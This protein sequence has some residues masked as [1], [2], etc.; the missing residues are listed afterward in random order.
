MKVKYTIFIA[1]LLFSFTACVNEGDNIQE[2]IVAL[3]E[4]IKTNPSQGDMAQLLG[5]YKK[6]AE[7]HQGDMEQSA[8]YL[9]KA[10]S[11]EYKLGNIPE[12]ASIL[13]QT[14]KAHF[15]ASTTDANV[16]ALTNMQQLYLNDAGAQDSLIESFVNSFP[17]KKAL[18]EKLNKLIAQQSANT[19]DSTTQKINEQA[20]LNY[21]N[22]SEVYGLA[23][24]DAPQAADNLMNAA[25]LRTYFRQFDRTLELYDIVHE[26]YAATDMGGN[27]LFLKAFTLDNHLQRFDDAKNTYTA[28]LEEYPEHKLHDS[29]KYQLE[30]LGKSAEEIIKGF[31]GN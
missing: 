21:M 2:Q 13:R 24:P 20:S 14:I 16:L 18:E 19:I 6:Y 27:A 12:A 3:E 11:L 31:Q 17:N 15:D 25:E 9:Q 5:L 7:E 23:L 4:R 1:I 8:D 26:R 30:N 10:A 28:F 22:L 29:A